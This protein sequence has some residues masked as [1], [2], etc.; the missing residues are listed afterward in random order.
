MKRPLYRAICPLLRRGIFS[1]FFSILAASCVMYYPTAYTAEE[2][3]GIYATN[4]GITDGDSLYNA[5]YNSGKG[6]RDA[7]QYQKGDDRPS[8]V[9]QAYYGKDID[10]KA[11]GDWD[12]TQVAY[13]PSYNPS[14]GPNG[15]LYIDIYN[16]GYGLYSYCGTWGSLCPWYISYGTWGY[17]YTWYSGYGTWGYLYPWY[18]P[19]Y[20][21][22]GVGRLYYTG[23]WVRDRDIPRRTYSKNPRYDSKVYRQVVPTRTYSRSPRRDSKTHRQ[24]A[25]SRTYH[26]NAVPHSN[27]STVGRHKSRGRSAP[28]R[29]HRR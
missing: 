11:Y 2:T 29:Y 22:W 24:T 7:S 19:G 20:R 8:L 5:D 25:P 27:P 16:Q 28:L 3:D 26:R 23:D 6:Y 15:D 17:P 14:V 10:L 18:Y 4:S 13:D 12:K 1:V 21:Y 9:Q